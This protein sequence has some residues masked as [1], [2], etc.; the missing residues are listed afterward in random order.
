MTHSQLC[1]H[2][3]KRRVKFKKDRTP[4]LWYKRSWIKCPQRKSRIERL[5]IRSPKKPHSARRKTAWAFITR[6]PVRNKKRVIM[7][8]KFKKVAAYIPGIGHS[9][10]K[11]SEILIR[12][13]RRR[14]IPGMKYTFIRGGKYGKSSWPIG[15][16]RKRSKY[17]I[18]RWVVR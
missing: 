17:G 7:F 1:R 15:R 12:G 13:G 3:T 14:D 4:D 2:K 6:P 8:K 9:W 16:R 18:P 10:H 5:D 11:Y